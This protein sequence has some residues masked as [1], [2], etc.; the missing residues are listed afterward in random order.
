SDKAVVYSNV[1]FTKTSKF[2]RVQNGKANFTNVVLLDE[3]ERQ[4]S[5]ANFGQIIILR[6]LV[7]SHEDIHNLSFGFHIRDR[8]GVDLLYDDSVLQQHPIVAVKPDEELIIDWKFKVLLQ[9]GSYIIA[10]V[11]SI[12]INLELSEVD[13]CDFVPIALQFDVHSRQDKVH[14]AVFANSSLIIKSA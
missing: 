14:A 7:K 2:Q 1:E 10:T 6:C 11:T 4:I 12:P 9:A 13:M 5:Y 3:H 8:N